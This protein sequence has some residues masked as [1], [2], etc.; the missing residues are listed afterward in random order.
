MVAEWYRD[1][2]HCDVSESEEYADILRNG[3][4]RN[5]KRKLLSTVS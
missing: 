2:R 3:T 1:M 4:R 5:S